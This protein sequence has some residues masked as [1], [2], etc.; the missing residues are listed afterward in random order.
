MHIFAW[1]PS[2]F[3]YESTQGERGLTFSHVI[4][5]SSYPGSECQRM[6]CVFVSCVSVLSWPAD[7]CPG[8]ELNGPAPSKTGWK[9]LQKYKLSKTAR[10]LLKWLW[11]FLYLDAFWQ[12]TYFTPFLHACYHTP[13]VA[14]KA[15]TF[16]HR[17]RGCPD[18][19]G[20]FQPVRLLCWQTW[21]MSNLSHNN[22]NLYFSHVQ[23]I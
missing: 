4:C 18:S 7:P 17:Y 22:N 2:V 16:H 11:D 8:I 12:R 9:F 19:G 15:H 5:A 20:Y 10:D 1:I 14:W 13:W 3:K 23:Q 21:N 6:Q